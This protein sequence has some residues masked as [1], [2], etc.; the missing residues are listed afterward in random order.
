M[1]KALFYALRRA[2]YS[3]VIAVTTYKPSGRWHGRRCDYNEVT[4]GISSDLCGLFATQEQA[5]ACR[6]HVRELEAEYDK[7]IKVHRDAISILNRDQRR[8]I[9]AYIKHATEE[10]AKV[11]A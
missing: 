4:H 8:D 11:P 9:E 7:K 10:A 6:A 2:L 5:E 3:P 1:K